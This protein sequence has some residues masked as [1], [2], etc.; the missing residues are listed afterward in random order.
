MSEWDNVSHYPDGIVVGKCRD[1][2]NRSCHAVQID[3]PGHAHDLLGVNSDNSAI[4]DSPCFT[5]DFHN[6]CAATF[7]CLFPIFICFIV[8]VCLSFSFASWQSVCKSVLA[9]SN[10]TTT[11]CFLCKQAAG[12]TVFSYTL[13][14][15]HL[16]QFFRV[17]WA[18]RAPWGASSLSERTWLRLGLMEKR[19]N[20][21]AGWSRGAGEMT[22]ENAD[23]Q[24][25]TC[26][27]PSPKT[28]DLRPS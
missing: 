16:Y 14:P 24:S 6:D 15:T 27:H 9:P 2:I 20:S 26:C 22:R 7:P 11:S 8:F 1:P 4:R 3:F 23:T 5:K 19:R 13:H 18:D 25:T 17:A 28:H 12:A 21:T 10:S